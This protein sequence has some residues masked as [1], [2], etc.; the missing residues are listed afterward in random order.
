MHPSF[1]LLAAVK[2]WRTLKDRHDQTLVLAKLL[3]GQIQAN[4]NG[5]R[6]TIPP[7]VKSYSCD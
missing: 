5:R 4:D 7:I 3:G 2:A 1:L 6:G